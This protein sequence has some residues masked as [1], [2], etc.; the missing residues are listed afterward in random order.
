MFVWMRNLYAELKLDFIYMVANI[1]LY[2]NEQRDRGV[3]EKRR[4]KPE[5][6]EQPLILYKLVLAHTFAF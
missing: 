3:C 4:R 6:G 5:N 1:G 2:L